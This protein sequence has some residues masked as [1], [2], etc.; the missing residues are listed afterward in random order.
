M[1]ASPAVVPKYR[2][3][4]PEKLPL[5]SGFCA[6]PNFSSQKGKVSFSGV[7]CSWEQ[8]GGAVCC[9]TTLQTEKKSLWLF[10]HICQYFVHFFLRLCVGLI[11]GFGDNFVVRS[12]GD[13]GANTLKWFVLKHSL[14]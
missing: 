5:H 14:L 11:S 13:A 10:Y 9:W 4:T 7:L 6:R 12:F 3:C 2:D 1:E 8:N